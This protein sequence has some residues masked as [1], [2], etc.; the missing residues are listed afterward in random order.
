MGVQIECEYANCNVI[1]KSIFC[2]KVEITAFAK[3]V[4]AQPIMSWL[5]TLTIRVRILCCFYEV[6]L[7]SWQAVQ[8]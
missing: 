6:I 5:E 1:N 3:S 7:M 2:L 8:K 4:Q